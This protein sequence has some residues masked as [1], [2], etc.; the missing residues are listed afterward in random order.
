MPSPAQPSPA[1]PSPAQPSP[2]QPS[3]AQ[4]SPAQ[5]SPASP[6]Q[7]SPAQPSPAQPSPAQPS[8][9]QP[10]PAQPSPAQPSP[11]QPSPAQPSP[12]QP[13]PAQPSP[14]QPSPAQPSPAQPSP[15]QPSPAQPSPAQPSP[16]Q[17]SPA[18]PS[19]AQPS[20]AQPSPAQPSPA[21]PSPAQPSPAQPSPAQPS[22]A[23][24]SPAQ[25][26]PAQPSPAQPSPAQPSPAQ[27]SPAQPSPAQPSPAQPSPTLLSHTA[28]P[29]EPMCES[30]RL[31]A[32]QPWARW[33]DI[34]VNA[35]G[36]PLSPCCLDM[37]KVFNN[38]SQPARIKVVFGA[39][40]QW[41]WLGHCTGAEH[42]GGAG[43]WQAVV[44]QQPPAARAVQ[45]GAVPFSK[46]NLLHAPALHIQLDSQVCDQFLTPRVVAA[47]KARTCKL[48]LTLEQQR[49]QSSREYTRLL[50]EVL[51]KLASCA[52]V[53]AC[54]LGTM[55]GPS[56]FPR[57]L[58]GFSPDLAQPWTLDSRLHLDFSSS[59]A[60]YLTDS[61]P[62]MTSLSLLGYAIPCSSLA[63]ML[64]HPQLNLQL[65]QLDLT[66][67]IIT[68]PKRPEP[69]AATLA[70]LFH[71]SRLKQLSLLISS[72]ADNESNDDM[73]EGENTPLLP[74][75]QPLSQHLTQLCLTLP[76]GVAWSLDEFTA[77]L[78][79]LAQ[80]QPDAGPH[81]PA[82]QVS[83]LPG[84]TFPQPCL[85]QQAAMSCRLQALQALW[86]M[87][88]RGGRAAGQQQA[89]DSK[90]TMLQDAV[91]LSS[92]LA[93]SCC[94]A[95]TI[96]YPAGCHTE[97]VSLL[98]KRHQLQT[99]GCGG[100]KGQ[101]RAGSA[102][103]VCTSSDCPH[104][105]QQSA[106]YITPQAAKVPAQHMGSTPH[107]GTTSGH[108][109]RAAH[110]ARL[111]G[112]ILTTP[113]HPTLLPTP[114]F[115]YLPVYTQAKRKADEDMLEGWLKQA[116][117]RSQ[118]VR[119]VDL[120]VDLHGWLAGRLAEVM[121]GRLAEVMAGMQLE[122]CAVTPG[123]HIG[124]DMGRRPIFLPL[125]CTHHLRAHLPC[126]L[127]IKL[128][129]PTTRVRPRSDA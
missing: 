107:V 100:G 121:A 11:A 4:P 19:P 32:E 38:H 104:S 36:R 98:L 26:S 41:L 33:L 73:V 77:S 53:E 110:Q 15:A 74:N 34:K 124:L 102:P 64:S 30:L 55:E 25:P 45:L 92:N 120:L 84:H 125:T 66:G 68:Q 114:P 57:T 47:L 116:G 117:L 80:L 63:S 115:T 126:P 113:S 106:H 7:P 72:M 89:T 91:V 14:A 29:T 49:A 127:C 94:L 108:Q 46:T 23:Q 105:S 59:L 78:Q 6:A 61:F 39:Q 54:K 88:Y 60:Q 21:Q 27:P 111:Q 5:P 12:A 97:A 48:A 96:H 18:Q 50:T 118:A 129:R 17:P 123:P 86:P 35:A 24:P 71:A 2:A 65:Q 8:P 10:S 9:A 22:P 13:S 58:L 69:G 43:A 79:P 31:V 85:E 128:A 70:N 82:G 99:A 56:L 75:L 37:N 44:S 40:C 1:Q 51:K 42:V 28:L 62:S 112:G 93:M 87:P 16:A 20:P 52:T 109:I 76:E 95:P 119:A 83:K 103:G 90:G 81:L 3:P 101:D 122:P 67:T